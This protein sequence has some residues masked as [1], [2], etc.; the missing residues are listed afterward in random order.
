MPELYFFTGRSGKRHRILDRISP[1]WEEFAF[2]LQF[3]TY[4]TEAVKRSSMFQVLDHP[5][6]PL[7]YTCYTS[8]YMHL[9]A[10]QK[11]STDQ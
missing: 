6:L 11:V 5:A 7:L 1:Y 10:G 8:T 9:K 3:E 2:A 4:I